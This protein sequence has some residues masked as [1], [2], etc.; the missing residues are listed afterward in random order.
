MIELDTLNYDANVHLGFIYQKQKQNEKAIQYYMKALKSNPEDVPTMGSIAKIYSDMG[1]KAKAVEMYERAVQYASEEQKNNIL[2]KLGAAYIADK[3]FDKSAEVFEQLVAAN[4]DKPAH[5]YNLGI[6]QM[7]LKKYNE[8]IPHLAKVIE[9]RPDYVGAYQQ[10]AACYNETAKYNDAISIVKKGLDMSPGNAGL[11]VTW[12][13][14]LEKMKLFD[15]AI[16]ILQKA[17]NDPQYGSYAKKQI[18]R[19]KK[20]KEREE[21]IKAQQM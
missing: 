6:S 17:V 13:T 19:Q 21:K 15:D 18:E 1:E 20:L 3:K 8:A 5:L 10:L 12:A 14:S 11:Y 2:S 9:L 4:P 16:A 7:Q